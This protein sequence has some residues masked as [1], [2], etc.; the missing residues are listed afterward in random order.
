MKKISH[1]GP[2]FIDSFSGYVA[3]LKPSHR[4]PSRVLEVLAKHPR[5]STWDM[6]ELA[7]LRGCI[8]VL[9]RDGLIAEDKSEQ[10]PWHRYNVTA[11]AHRIQGVAK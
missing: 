1:F 2:I 10:Y 11:A 4:T 6:S 8:D 9:E 5:V 3:Y 7:W